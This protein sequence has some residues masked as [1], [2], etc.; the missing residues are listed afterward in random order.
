MGEGGLPEP[1]AGTLKHRYPHACFLHRPEGLV[2]YNKW[3]SLPGSCLLMG[4]PDREEAVLE[5]ETPFL[6]LA[7]LQTPALY[8]LGH[9]TPGH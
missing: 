9:L 6:C 7:C 5:H 2:S 3:C 1:D 4:K 8:Q